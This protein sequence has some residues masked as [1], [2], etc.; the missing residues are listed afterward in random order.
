M[1][2]SVR[3]VFVLRHGDSPYGSQQVHADLETANDLTLHGCEQVRWTGQWIKSCFGSL[4]PKVERIHFFSSTYGRTWH[5][6]RLLME[7]CGIRRDRLKAFSEPRLRDDHWLG[8][9]TNQ[10]L[11]SLCAVLRTAMHASADAVVIVTHAAV[12]LPLNL[13]LGHDVTGFD[14][15]CGVRLSVRQD[16]LYF[17]EGHGMVVKHSPSEGLI[18]W[19]QL[20]IA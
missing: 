9:D 16:E 6:T 19:L 10:Q 2:R 14:P 13:W 5:T 7:G 4:Q 3:S 17:E 18:H 20:A 12:T 11:R 1:T 8:R 15:A